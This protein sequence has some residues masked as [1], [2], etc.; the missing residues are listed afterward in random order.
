MLA[1]ALLRLTAADG[2]ALLRLNAADLAATSL[3][4]NT[5]DG[6]ALLRLTCCRFGRHVAALKCCPWPLSLINDQVRV[7]DTIAATLALPTRT[8]VQAFSWFLH[9]LAVF[10]TPG[11]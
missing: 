5:A 6:R 1:A 9:Y 2:R 10:P 7:G 3:R 11:T 8:R 4:W